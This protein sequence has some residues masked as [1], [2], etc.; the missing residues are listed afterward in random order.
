ML[1]ILLRLGS[2]LTLVLIELLV[3]LRALT[4]ELTRAGSTGCGTSCSSTSCSSATVVLELVPKTNQVVDVVAELLL[5]LGSTLSIL[6]ARAG[7][8][9]CA[10]AAV[11][12]LKRTIRCG[13]SLELLT[14]LALTSLS[15]TQ[16]KLEVRIL[17]LELGQLRKRRLLA[18][19]L[20]LS[21]AQRR[22]L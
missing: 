14:G 21:L 18:G 22:L 7:K 5:G 1:E 2:R 6:G 10:Q 11:S 19:K 3:V 8:M 16:L 4:R 15:R 17:R 12:R 9:T 20:L 13:H